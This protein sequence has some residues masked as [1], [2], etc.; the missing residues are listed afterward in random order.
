MTPATVARSY[1]ESFASGD[2]TTIVSHV[3]DGFLNEHTS[4]LGSGCVGKAAYHER[5]PGFLGAMPGLRYD[6]ESV[7]VQGDEAA[8]FYTLRADG[9]VEVRGCMHLWV[10]GDGLIARRVDYWDSLTY[11]RQTGQA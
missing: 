3:A 6:V 2:P 11:L 10:D 7:M 9:G 4:A 5:L 8:A 1:L